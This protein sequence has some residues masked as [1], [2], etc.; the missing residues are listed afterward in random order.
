MNRNYLF[1]LITLFSFPFSGILGQTTFEMSED[2]NF[3]FSNTKLE[4]SD[5]SKSLRAAKRS[6]GGK[7]ILNCTYNDP[8]S[9]ELLTSLE[10]AAGV[11]RDYIPYGDTLRI[12]V[13]FEDNLD[14]DIRLNIPY[15]LYNGLAYPMSLAR[16]RLRNTSGNTCDAEI[17][18]NKSSEWSIGIGEE[19]SNTPKNLTLAFMQCISRCLGFGSSVKENDNK[20]AFGF[21]NIPSVFDN[22]IVNEK[23]NRLADYINDENGLKSFSTGEAGS[24]YFFSN[25]IKA[26]L[27]TPSVF[28]NNISLR[29]TH[30]EKSLMDYYSNVNTDLTVDD[31][32]LNML[33]ELGWEFFNQSQMKIVSDDMDTTGIT[34]AYTSH[35]FY[36]SQNNRNFTSR[37]WQLVLPL[38]DGS[39]TTVCSSEDIL[40]TVPAISQPELYEHTIE[41]DIRGMIIF[42]GIENTET[43]TLTCPVIFELKP[44]V[45]SAKVIST[46]TNPGNPN[47]YDALVGIKYEGSHDIHASVEEENS[48]YLET[49]YS[50]TPYYAKMQL[51][52]ISSMDN[53]WLNI[54]VRNEYGSDDYILELPGNASGI[55]TD[56]SMEYEI[57]RIEIYDLQGRLIGIYNNLS[58]ATIPEGIYLMKVYGRENICRKVSKVCVD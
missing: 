49:Y 52:N 7:I 37:K 18:I 30:N 45:I 17:Y 16:N 26:G 4:I 51:T 56:A 8:V 27:Y 50:S 35:N 9:E 53:A 3:D 10:V 13:F 29:Y 14:S 46:N 38:A 5:N 31:L 48:P 15:Q 55:E 2:I 24:V 23:G 12:N 32:T 36:I 19:N 22:C 54:T 44:R 6:G 41:G 57:S 11:W 20:I 47:Y 34:S 43:V 1:S 25:G 39:S 21:D 58:D 28:N 42:E 33:N 40:F